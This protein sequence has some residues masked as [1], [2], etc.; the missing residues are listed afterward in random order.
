VRELI[1]NWRAMKEAQHQAELLEESGSD[2]PI[3]NQGE[4][5]VRQKIFQLRKAEIKHASVVW[6]L[7]EDCWRDS[8]MATNA[9]TEQ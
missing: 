2:L 3:Q 9:V 4:I 5:Q 1:Q 6:L 8:E 7:D